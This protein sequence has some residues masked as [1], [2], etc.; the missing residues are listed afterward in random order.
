MSNFPQ[1]IAIIMDGN[2]RWAEQRNLPRSDGHKK[3]LET[4]E[5]IISHCKDIGIKYLSL[6]VFSTENWK[7][8]KEEVANLFDL[9]YRY[10]GRLD[11]FCK[12]DI[13]IVVSGDLTKLPTKLCKRIE[14]IQQRTQNATALCLNL[15]IN[16]GGR[17]E[18]AVACQRV[19][20]Q[21]LQVT[22]QNIL[23]N[24]YQ[25]LPEPEIVVRTGGH[26]R[27]SNFLLFQSAYSELYFCDTF[28]PDFDEKQLD[29]IVADYTSVTRN[30]GGLPNA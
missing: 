14:K 30:F 29:D 7:R 24:L 1:H 25:N 28:W 10:L 11:N 5:R 17:Q 27:L 2:G 13:K 22:E 4:V 6:Y 20:Q 16:Y 19:L 9:A 3:G 15:C 12:Q 23:Q 8:S 26:K 18:I 21:G